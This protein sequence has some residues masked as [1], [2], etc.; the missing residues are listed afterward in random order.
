MHT[1]TVNAKI[2]GQL[3]WTL[4]HLGAGPTMKHIHVARAQLSQACRT[5]G[6]DG[7]RA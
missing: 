5:I 1:A 4:Q 2:V 6:F 7:I 3:F